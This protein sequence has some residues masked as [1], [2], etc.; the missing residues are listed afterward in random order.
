MGL[1]G[2]KKILLGGME[3]G[4]RGETIYL[5]RDIEYFLGPEGCVP[6]THACNGRKPV[7][8]NAVMQ[9]DV[10][11]VGLNRILTPISGLAG[12][13]IVLAGLLSSAQVPFFSLICMLYI[14]L[15][16]INVY[17][18]CFLFLLIITTSYASTE[19]PYRSGDCKS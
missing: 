11:R 1:M 10:S 14:L 3:G 18:S 16:Y 9:Q 6:D 19:Q 4:F 13:C 5:L 7:F 8:D 17:S 2:E 15:I 12:W